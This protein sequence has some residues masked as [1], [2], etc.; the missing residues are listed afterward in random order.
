[1]LHPAYPEG[2]WVIY[3]HILVE[4]G[5][6]QGAVACLICRPVMRLSPADSN[7]LRAY[8]NPSTLT[9]MEMNIQKEIRVIHERNSRKRK[10][11]N[12]PRCAQLWLNREGG[13][14]QHL[15][16]EQGVSHHTKLQG[17]S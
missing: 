1:M 14:L 17:S 13:N 5:V 6:Q 8:H 15:L 12:W 3:T 7:E 10:K 16:I 11:M 4:D 2:Q 9:E